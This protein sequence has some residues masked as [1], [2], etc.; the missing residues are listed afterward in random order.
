[1]LRAPPDFVGRGFLHQYPHSLG[2]FPQ[3]FP[4]LRY[5]PRTN[6]VIVP[7]GKG[8]SALLGSLDLA[9]K[10]KL[11]GTSDWVWIGGCK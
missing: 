10:F 6:T 11:R 8:A 1:M 5:N 2:R 4:R 9:A 7:K 3:V